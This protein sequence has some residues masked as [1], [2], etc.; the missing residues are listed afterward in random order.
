MR[1]VFGS[2]SAKRDDRVIARTLA[3]RT[4]PPFGC[5]NQGMKP[6]QRAGQPRDEL[7]RR[8][9]T[10]D[11]RELVTKHDSAMILGPV[12]RIFRQK[13]DRSTRAPRKGSAH[14]RAG[15]ET[16]RL[17]DGGVLAFFSENAAP[18]RSLEQPGVLSDSTEPNSTQ[19]E[20]QDH[21]NESRP[22]YDQRWRE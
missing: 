17:C 10:R 20:P 2:R 9:T 5:P 11:V 14:H 8:V 3:F 15:V 12:Q 22:P 7:C 16:H 6:V 19:D 21:G 4:Q 18:I 1:R 13:N